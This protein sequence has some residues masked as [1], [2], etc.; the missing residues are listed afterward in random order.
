MKKGFIIVFV[1]LGFQLLQ[2]TTYFKSWVGATEVTS[3]TQGDLYAWEYDV[4]VPGGMAHMSIYID[5]NS[6]QQIDSSDVLMIEFDQQDGDTENDGPGDSSSVADG[7]IY[8]MMGVFGLA[9]GDYLYLVED[10]NDN[11]SISSALHVSPPANVTITLSG[12]ISKKGVTAPDDQLANIIIEADVETDNQDIGFWM[13]MTDADGNYSINM[14]DSALNETWKISPTFNNQFSPYIPDPESYHD[15]SVQ[16]GDNAPFDFA[17][18]LPGTWVYGSVLDENQQLVN[19]SDG[20]SLENQNS[21]D[22]TDFQISDGIFLVGAIFQGDDTTNVPFNFSIW[23]DG[24]VPDYMVPNTWNEEDANYNFILSVGDSVEK[25]FYVHHTDALVYVKVLKDGTV[26]S[27]DE[28][29][30]INANNDS[31]GFTWAVTNNSGFAELHVVSGNIYN[32]WFNTDDDSYPLPQGYFIEE[33]TGSTASPNDTVIFHLAQATNYLA[34]SIHIKPGDES[35]FDAD[36]VQINTFNNSGG[37]YSTNISPDSL[38]YRL[39]LGNGDYTVEFNSFDGNFLA[40]P[41]RYENVQIND[42]PIDTLDFDLSFAHA[43]LVVKLK[44]APNI[45]YEW[46]SIHTEGVYPNFYQ[47]NAQMEAADSSYYFGVCDGNWQIEAPWF[48]GYTSNFSDSTVRVLD[49]ETQYFIEIQYKL[50]TGIETGSHVPEQF[51][52][53]QNYPNP[54]GKGSHFQSNSATTI[55]FG[56]AKLAPVQVYIYDLEGRRVAT[57]LKQNLA[58]GIHKIRWNAGQFASGIYFYQ[59][60]TPQKSITK[61]LLLL[62]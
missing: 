34:G 43:E 55:E 7:I 47:S 39:Y 19:V 21:G 44:G 61:R 2:A 16:S 62:K 56:L 25:N 37:N 24:L 11:S 26:P 41:F 31:L 8:S 49:G 29:F 20:G 15:Q 52:V 27:E 32:I 38:D 35:H 45:Q 48:D 5:V 54:F 6:N 14:P 57:L 12:T 23:G 3:M 53:N 51:Y 13:G 42:R 10:Q 59:V 46:M 58:A 30:R 28:H 60:V 18:Q 22:I 40:K 33:G 36:R 1:L 9:P 17:F 50:N 4:S